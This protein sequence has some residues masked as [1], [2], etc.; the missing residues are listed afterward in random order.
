MFHIVPPEPVDYLVIGHLT[1][2]LTP[3]GPALGGS[4]SYA[5]LTAR[6]LGL[7]VGV[8]T[9]WGNEIELSVLR[10]IPKISAPHCSG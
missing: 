4:A 1:V 10:D 3:S 7:R 5:A 9:A 6:A 8:V 2:D